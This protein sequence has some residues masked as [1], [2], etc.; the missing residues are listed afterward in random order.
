MNLDP[1]DLRKFRAFCAEDDANPAGSQA[2]NLSPLEVEAKFRE[3]IRAHGLEPPDVIIPGKWHRFPGAGKRP[4]NKAG[5]CRFFADGKGGVFGDWSTGLKKTWFVDQNPRSRDQIKIY[6]KQAQQAKLKR[7][8]AAAEKQAQATKEAQD[9]W[10]RAQP[11]LDWH[12]YLKRKRIKPHNLRAT[13]NGEL[14]API[15]DRNGKLS[16]VQKIYQGAGKFEKRFHPGCATGGDRHFVIGGPDEYLSGAAEGMDTICVA[17][18]VATAASIHEA[19]EYPTV[20]AFSDNKL[21]PVARLVSERYPNSQIKVCADNDAGTEGNPGVEKATKAAQAVR[22]TLAM[23]PA[24]D[25]ESVDFNDLATAEGGNAIATIINKTDED[26]DKRDNNP[27]PHPPIEET[28]NRFFESFLHDGFLANDKFPIDVLP[29]ILKNA[30]KDV[31]SFSQTDISMCA[32]SARSALSVVMQDC[33]DVSRTR[34]PQLKSPTSLFTLIIAESGE[35]KTQNDKIFFKRIY[36]FDEKMR[37]ET[38]KIRKTY[39]TDHKNWEAKQAILIK[40]YTKAIEEK[41]KGLEKKSED[42]IQKHNEAEPEP[43]IVPQLISQDTTSE[44]MLWELKS[45]WPSVGIMSS[46]GGFVT[47]SHSMNVE[48]ITKTF[49]QYNYLWEDQPLHVR[50]RRS[51]SFVVSNA[52]LSIGLQIQ[53]QLFL[54]FINKGGGLA[55]A[56]GTLARFLIIHPK[57]TRGDRPFKEP[58]DK[59]ES[60]LVFESLLEELLERQK[61]DF[62]QPKNKQKKR[63]PRIIFV[64]DKEAKNLW[65][66]FFNDTERQQKPDGRYSEIPDF[67]SKAGDIVARI[68]AQNQ[69]LIDKENGIDWSNEPWEKDGFR[70]GKREISGEAMRLAI[71]EMYWYLHQTSRILGQLSSPQEI[72]DADQIVSWMRRNGHKTIAKRELQKLVTPAALRNGKRFQ[73]ALDDLMEQDGIDITIKGRSTY[74]Q[75]LN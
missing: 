74:I 37:E 53:E 58:P 25:G 73:P 2:T 4:K 14:L 54:E 27:E 64:F 57:T 62:D 46:E 26:I 70:K 66:A 24:P 65:I 1:T 6:Q 36:E 50:R 19:T 71:Q 48:S 47:G 16:S 72:K 69:V 61:P 40:E 20:V 11:A 38:E 8:I 22:A 17:E 56:G 21:E 63:D 67:V 75:L 55:R 10:D 30:V 33:F 41:D 31:Q 13:A 23:P 42:E 29:S 3:E 59:W 34:G 44:A 49:A 39:N 12:P 15:Y 32:L 35:R 51:E 7:Q 45:I 43:P 28:S 60:V 52:R 18:G 68:A 5:W 9:I